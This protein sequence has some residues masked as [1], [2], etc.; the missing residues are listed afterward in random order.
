LDVYPVFI[1]RLPGFAG[2]VKLKFVL[3]IKLRNIE[4]LIK[5]AENEEKK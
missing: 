3:Q 2:H 1:G 5:G 4:I